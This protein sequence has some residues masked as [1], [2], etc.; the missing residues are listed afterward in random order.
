LKISCNQA[1]V[2]GIPADNLTNLSLMGE[3]KIIRL[4]TIR[5]DNQI[6]FEVPAV[7]NG[8]IILK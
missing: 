6:I 2:I 8:E 7:T 1:V 5:S 3:G 4:K